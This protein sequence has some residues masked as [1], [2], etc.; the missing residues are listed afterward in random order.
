MAVHKVKLSIRPDETIEVEDAEL[1]DL[2][3][4]GLVV[5]ETKSRKSADSD[6]SDKE[7]N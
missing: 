6:K 7:T 4:Y 2:E 1:A 5:K 3:A